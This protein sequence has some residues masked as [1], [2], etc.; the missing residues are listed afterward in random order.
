MLRVIYKA[1]DDLEPGR[2][3]DFSEDRGCVLVR[4]AKGSQ[5]EDYVRALNEEMQRFLDNSS[6]FQLWRDQILSRNHPEFALD[7]TFRLDDL[8]PGEGVK[9]RELKGTVDIRVERGLPVEAFV[10]AINPAIVEFLD[11]GQWFQLFGGEIVDIASPD[12]MSEV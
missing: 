9:I 1:V 5:P 2:L 12:S 6:W 4:V 3:A 10:A 11:G 8:G 7:V